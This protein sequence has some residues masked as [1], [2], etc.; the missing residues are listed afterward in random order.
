MKPMNGAS[1]ST[2]PNI[3]HPSAGR[4]QAPCARLRQ[5][6]SGSPWRSPPAR[7]SR[8][9]G[10]ALALA[11]CADEDRRPGAVGAPAL[12]DAL[13]LL[14][15][16]GGRRAVFPRAVVMGDAGRAPG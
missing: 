16:G 5:A 8:G 3:S 2:G 15:R 9:E 1:A 12:R 14:A 11:G 10:Q 6:A 7:L 13:D 4:P